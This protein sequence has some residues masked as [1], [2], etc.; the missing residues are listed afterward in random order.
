MF[1]FSILH[2]KPNNIQF[3]FQ[4]TVML[5]WSSIFSKYSSWSLLV[6]LLSQLPLPPSFPYLLQFILFLTFLLFLTLKPYLIQ[7]SDLT[8]PLFSTPFFFSSLSR[9]VFDNISQLHCNLYFKY[10]Q[11]WSLHLQKKS[12][13]TSSPQYPNG[14]TH[15]MFPKLNSW[16][17]LKNQLCFCSS[18]F[19]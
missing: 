15:S 7:R 3:S 8:S 1:W 5:L 13:Y 2:S 4:C 19:T 16:S 9:L 6:L 17:S 12:C 10:S 18:H 11:F 14:L